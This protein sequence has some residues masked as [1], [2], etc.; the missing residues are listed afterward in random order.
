MTSNL[1]EKYN[2]LYFLAA[3]G[4]GGLA[5]GFFMYLLFMIKHPGTPITTF[6]HIYPV[7]SRGDMQSVLVGAALVGII[8]FAVNHFR[9]LFWNIREFRLYSETE[10]CDRLHHCNSEISLM[11]IPL[12]LA[13]SINVS[14]IL[15]AVFVPGL[16]SIVEYLFPFALAGFITVGIYAFRIFSG[17]LGRIIS[18]GTFDFEANNNLSQLLAPF[19]FS[20]IAVGAAAPGAMS[21][22]VAVSTVGIFFAILFGVAA[23]TLTLVFLVL[24]FMSML[25]KG[26]GIES[27]PSLWIVIPIATVLG[28]AFVRVTSGISH[29]LLHLNSAPP[30]IMFVGLGILLSLQIFF[31]L[32][33]YN[34]LKKIGYFKDYIHGDKKSAG[35]FA[36]ICPG[37][38]FFVMGM[39]FVDWGLVKT[40]ILSQF[41]TVYFLILL[42]FI[43]VQVITIKTLFRLNH[44]LLSGRENPPVALSAGNMSS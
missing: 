22:N 32:V 27:S 29:N 15:G 28:I 19:A 20:M 21:H 38:A 36:L 6:D 4:N 17:Y 13:M 33:G 34:T 7:L 39:F 37:V 42:P 24:G 40:G 2:P 12:T 9:L 11:A 31:G 43:Y 10:A 18:T 35:S 8:Y 44:K 41:S 23:I 3:L 5:I 30:V 1:R 25:K 16:W 14:F 26:V